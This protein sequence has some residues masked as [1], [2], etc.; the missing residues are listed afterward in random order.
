VRGV[1]PKS[2][3]AGHDFQKGNLRSRFTAVSCRSRLSTCALSP[4]RKKPKISKREAAAFGGLN[5]IS[6]HA[7]AH[8]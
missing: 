7:A 3:S 4:Q 8:L 1:I 2:G 6:W 5:L